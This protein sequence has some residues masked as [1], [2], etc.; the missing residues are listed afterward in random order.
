MVSYEA[1]KLNAP[2]AQSFENK[3][4]A[5]VAQTDTA[6]IIM[7]ELWQPELPPKIEK[8]PSIEQMR[9]ELE[10][11]GVNFQKTS[12]IGQ[13]LDRLIALIFINKDI[14][15]TKYKEIVGSPISGGANRYAPIPTT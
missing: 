8:L 12:L 5:H 10:E 7:G 9:K 6:P 11:K 4:R 15:S 3:R 13:D 1:A 2:K 14:M